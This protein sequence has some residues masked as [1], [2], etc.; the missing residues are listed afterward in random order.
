MHNI[1]EGAE[2]ALP[3]YFATKNRRLAV[4]VA[5]ASGLAEPLGVL[6]VLLIGHVRRLRAASCLSILPYAGRCTK[7]QL[8]HL[9]QQ[10]LREARQIDDQPTVL[11]PA[12]PPSSP[13]SHTHTH[14]QDQLTP[15]RV[16]CLLA[17]VGGVM[18]ALSLVEL[19]PQSRLSCSARDST[20]W[21]LGKAHSAS[22]RLHACHAMPG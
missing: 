11:K 7:R 4:L 5:L 9:A 18:I 6:F 21:F 14:A 1:P 13:F 2:V 20:T 12:P 17:A 10:S 15:Q 3:V 8:M 16:A 22:P 19:L